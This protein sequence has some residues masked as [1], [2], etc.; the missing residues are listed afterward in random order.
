MKLPPFHSAV[1]AAGLLFVPF[2]LFAQGPEPGGGGHEHEHSPLQKEMETINRDARKL[3]RQYSDAA[4]KDSSLQLVAEMQKSAETAR[5]LT[6]SKAE[7]LSGAE[8]TKYLDTF[9]KDMDSLLTEIHSLKEAID[10][11]QSDK[12]KA[13]LDKINQLKMSSHKE[14]GVQMGPGPGGRRGPGGPGRPPGNDQKDGGQPMASPTA[15]APKPTAAP[16]D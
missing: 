1:V 11:G 5:D 6:P 10:A 14:L 2:G 12:I 3:N 7:K 13:E 8:K 4:Q 15:S 16:T 9:K